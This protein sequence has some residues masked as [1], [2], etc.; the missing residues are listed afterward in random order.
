[1][2]SIVKVLSIETGH[3]QLGLSPESAAIRRYAARMVRNR[4]IDSYRRERRDRGRIEGM[5]ADRGGSDDSGEEQRETAELKKLLSQLSQQDED[6]LRA[7][8]SGEPF[9]TQE[10]SLQ[11]LSRGTARV[12]IHRAM[13]KLR[14]LKEA[15]ASPTS[16][17]EK[18]DLDST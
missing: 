18:T 11:G 1:M 16:L 15:T 8:A 4:L 3:G 14:A 10:I 7:Y 2:D 13:N 6:L 5:A 9:L 12:R 17:G